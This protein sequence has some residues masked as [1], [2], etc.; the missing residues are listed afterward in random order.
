M[1][2]FFKYIVLCLLIIIIILKLLDITYT[3]AYNKGKRT[4]FQYFKSFENTSIDYILLGSSRVENGLNPD[5]IEKRIGKKVVNFGV[6]GARIDDLLLYL[7]LIKN[8]NIAHERIYIQMD[9]IYNMFDVKSN[10]L[11]YQTIP[12]L[13]ENDAIVDYHQTTP[14]ITSLR[15]VPFIRYALYDHKNGVRE[16]F[17]NVIG[18]QSNTN[19]H[20]GFNAVY[21]T[22]LSSNMKLPNVISK[23]NSSFE[24]LLKFIKQENLKVSFFCSPFR[25]DTENLNYVA[26]LKQVIPDLIDYSEAIEDKSLFKDNFHVNKKGAILFSELFAKNLI[27]DRLNN[28]R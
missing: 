17:S 16:L 19:Q 27:D 9:Y 2:A 3:S 25:R 5:I 12:F 20:K 14:Y 10:I 21:G 15:Y 24:Q 8:Y 22:N 11:T 7:K 4:K 13:I 6:Q 18:K 23:R 1:K 28:N 26:K